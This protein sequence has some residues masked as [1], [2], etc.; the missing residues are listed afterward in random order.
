V[1]K[2]S[3]MAKGSQVHLTHPTRG[4]NLN[5]KRSSESITPA[6]KSTLVEKRNYKRVTACND[7]DDHDCSDIGNPPTS[8]IVSV[9]KHTI[10]HIVPRN[11]GVGIVIAVGST[12]PSATKG[13]CLT[14]VAM[15]TAMPPPTQVVKKQ[16]IL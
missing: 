10:S 12:V 8:D 11:T 2:N 4:M 14:K 7:V 3:D 16:N 13:P 5:N 9:P 15:A 1:I 6:D